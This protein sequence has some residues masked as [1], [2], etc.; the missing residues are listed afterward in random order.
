MVQTHTNTYT[1]KHTHIYIYTYTEWC[2]EKPNFY[3]NKG[4]RVNVGM[5]EL[6]QKEQ[7]LLP[8][9]YYA[10]SDGD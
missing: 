5:F 4:F 10:V 8:Q 6:L 2:T 3:F 1:N 7:Q 9:I